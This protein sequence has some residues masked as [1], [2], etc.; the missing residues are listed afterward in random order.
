MARSRLGLNPDGPVDRQI[1]LIRL[2]RP[3]GSPIA[4]VANYAIHGTVLSGDN[5]NQRRCAGHRCAYVERSWARRCCSSTEPPAMPRRSTR[6]YPTPKS[7]HLRQFRVLLGDRILQANAAHVA[8]GT[9]DVTLRLDETV[10]ET[11]AQ[12]RASNGRRNSARYSRADS[13]AECSCGCRSVSSD[14]RAPRSG[15][16]Q[17]SC[18]PRSPSTVRNVAV[19]QTFYFGYTNGW[20]GYLPTA[21][22]V[23]RRRIRADDLRSHRRRRRRYTR[24][25]VTYLQG[26]EARCDGVYLRPAAVSFGIAAAA[27]KELT[28]IG[29]RAKYWAFQKVARPAVPAD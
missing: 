28:F 27:D 15:R 9:A 18:S 26:S 4:F 16:R 12:G 2:E 23:R 25:V 22:G 29:A 14:K 21:R 7:G 6:V 19:H 20:F 17:W 13:P 10:V 24:Q 5:G 3:D 1:G 8:K 11:P